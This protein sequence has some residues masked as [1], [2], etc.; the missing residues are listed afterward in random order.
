MS[1]VFD[2]DNTLTK[3]H[4]PNFINKIKNKNNIQKIN[5][6]LDVYKITDIFD[7]YV[8][9]N[10]FRELLKKMV[11]KK[12]N[13]IIMSYGYYDVILYLLREI[14][15]LDYIS[16]I[17]TPD[18]F[19]LQDGIDHRYMLQGKN[20]MLSKLRRDFEIKSNKN[21]LLIDDCIINIQN[22][23]KEGYNVY[24]VKN[25]NIDK[26]LDKIYPLFK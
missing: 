17:Y 8:L 25:N 15:I 18:E 22:A 14:N 4:V 20:V 10:K 9:S 5:I 2:F 23:K 1:V 21:I 13:I 12:C 7:P 16:Y 3:I 11:L 26:L 6:L 24:L 19:Q